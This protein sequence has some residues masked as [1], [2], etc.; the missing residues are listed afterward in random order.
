MTYIG[1]FDGYD[2]ENSSLKC[3]SQLHLGLLEALESIDSSKIQFIKEKYQFDE[4]N[5]LEKFDYSNQDQDENDVKILADNN[6]IKRKFSLKNFIDDEY[7]LDNSFTKL[8]NNLIQSYRNAFKY[9]FQEMDK[10]LARGQDETSK[11]RWSG[12]TACC[13]IIEKIDSSAWIHI[14]NCGKNI[15]CLIFLIFS[16]NFCRRCRSNCCNQLSKIC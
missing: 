9:S 6:H 5:N 3:C 12:S 8:E 14:A 16:N 10:L 2:G 1:T 15:I 13:C 11:T 7:S 4:I